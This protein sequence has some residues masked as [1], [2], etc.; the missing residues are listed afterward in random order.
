MLNPIM[1]LEFMRRFRSPGAALAIPLALLLPGLAV[2]SV[3]MGAVGFSGRIGITNDVAVGMVDGI[4]IDGGQVMDL[5]SGSGAPV[6]DPNTLATTGHGMFIA[7][8]VTLFITLAVL[9]PAFVGPSIAGERHSQTLQPL[10]LTAMR[11]G[12]IISG[13]LM[14]SLAYLL[15]VLVSAL[16]VIAIPF[17]I[18]GVEPV[19]IATMIG[20][21]MLVVI[22][23]AAVSLAI[24]A[25]MS[26]P[27]TATIASLLTVGF[28][29]VAPLIVMGIASL[30]VMRTNQNFSLE[31]SW[32]R[33]LAGPSPVS[34]GSLTPLDNGRFNDFITSSDRL[35]A[36]TCWALVT[37]VAL[38]IARRKVTAPVEKDR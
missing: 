28:L 4:P 27:A 16:P 6:V 37:L 35:V 7:V 18:G 15:L 12:Q 17:L 24:S 13:K 32:V 29:T 38:L 36:V 10:Q 31:H 9:V 14:S 1:R 26:R 5:G 2:V 19:S 34:L 30:A 33:Y 22:E 11:P 23:L 3:Y 21:M 8:I 20:V 25:I